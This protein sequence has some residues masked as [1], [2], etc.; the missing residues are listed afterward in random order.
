[1]HIEQI[2]IVIRMCV[3]KIVT[4]CTSDITHVFCGTVPGMLNMRILPIGLEG[5]AERVV[6]AKPSPPSTFFCFSQHT[7]WGMRSSSTMSTTP[8]QIGHLSRL[9]PRD[10]ITSTGYQLNGL[11]PGPLSLS[12]ASNGA[13]EEDHDSN[14]PLKL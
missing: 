4:D 8:F 13:K 14:P 2:S 11:S 7:N 3:Y 6:D 1:M 5:K 9:D 10:V 12:T